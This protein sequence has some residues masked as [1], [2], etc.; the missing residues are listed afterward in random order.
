LSSPPNSGPPDVADIRRAA[1]RIA[2]E[3]VV[4]PLVSSPALDA[5]LEGRIFL[6]CENLQRTGTFKFRGAYNA[7]ASLTPE[8]RNRGVVAVSSGN[9]AQGVAE[10]A[11]IFGVPATIV[12]PA[13]APAVKRA[14]V[15]AS[16]ARLIEYDRASEDREV[17][18]AAVVE[19]EGGAF[20]HP[21]N[22][23]AVIAGQGTIGLEI[24]ATLKA[25]GIVP[26][27][28][29]APCG[30]GGLTGGLGTAIKAEVPSA[31][32]HIVE[33]AGF[34]EYGRSLREGRII[35]NERTSG[36]VCD[37][38]LAKAP[39]K[40]GFALNQANVTS[41]LSVS[42]EE[43]LAAVAYAFRVLKLVV[44]PG[45]AVAL[46]ALLAGRVPVAGRTVVAVLSGGNIDP[47]VM[48]R[49]LASAGPSG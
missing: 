3:A 7:L 28:V 24:A 32:F 1:E 25:G 48:A 36:S 4:T 29:L 18:A 22:D 37:S 2:G 31:D 30:G 39:G 17:V 26:D 15:L 47:A 13:D 46:A 38:L 35:A 40:L 14:G 12:M 10:A 43:A 21:Y 19:R 11:R 5:R 41:A 20:V 6:K 8:E 27:A 23:A 9:H 45:G 42:D 49:A 34:D 44:E 33:P 16:G